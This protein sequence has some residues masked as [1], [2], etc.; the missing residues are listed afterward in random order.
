MQS[1]LAKE[2]R[3]LKMLQREQEMDSIPTGL[4]KNWIDPLPEGKN[5]TNLRKLKWN[6][7]IY[8]KTGIFLIFGRS[9]IRMCDLIFKNCFMLPYSDLLN[10]K[11]SSGTQN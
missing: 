5:L 10:T 7:Y 6:C 2:R 4:N 1:A 9:L 8:L 3:E 11:H